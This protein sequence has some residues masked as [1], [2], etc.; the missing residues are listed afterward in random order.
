M[1]AVHLVATI[2]N[3]ILLLYV[4]VL[5][6][7]MVLD[8]IPMFNRGWRP[9]GP[10]LIVA[11]VVYTV[12]DPPIRFLR[13]F[14]KPVRIGPVAIDFAFTIVLLACFVLLSITRVLMVV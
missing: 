7:R 3:G 12:T 1:G 13:R 10:W 5:L 14:L 11:E 4:L 9:T 6:A 2:L 8:Y